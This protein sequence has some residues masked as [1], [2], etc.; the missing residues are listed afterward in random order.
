MRADAGTLMCARLVSV[1][2]VCAPVD[3]PV[4]ACTGLRGGKV[5]PLKS[6]V[7][8]ALPK[9]AALGTTVETVLVAHR[10]GD[11][12]GPGVPGWVAGRD[13]S[14]DAAVA[15]VKARTIDVGLPVVFPAAVMDAEDPLF[16]LYTSG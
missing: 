14:L 9:A 8:A 11:G 13:Q 15:A 2:C 4:A 7:D 10:A 16:I 6:I 12:T 5:V 3:H 1:Q